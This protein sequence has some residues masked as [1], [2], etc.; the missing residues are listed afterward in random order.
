MPKMM[1]MA[2]GKRP[3][4]FDEYEP[5]DLLNKVELAA[6][7]SVSTRTVDRW[8]STGEAPPYVVLPNNRLRWKWADVL[9]WLQARRVDGT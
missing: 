3:K 2:R 1:D 4:K 6:A 5:G 9:V 7:L 8:V